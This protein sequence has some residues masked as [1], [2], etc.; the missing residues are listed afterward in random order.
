MVAFDEAEPLRFVPLGVVEQ[1]AALRQREP[2]A[3]AVILMDADDRRARFGIAGDGGGAQPVHV[4]A[5]QTIAIV[6]PHAP[7]SRQP[8]RTACINENRLRFAGCVAADRA[9]CFVA[10]VGAVGGL[11]ARGAWR[12]IR[13]VA[14]RSRVGGGRLAIGAC[15]MRR[16]PLRE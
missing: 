5:A 1:R 15:G 2:H 8:D 4:D 16:E 12:S 10:S 14:A 13:L 7:L 6:K 3:T 11:W 9:C